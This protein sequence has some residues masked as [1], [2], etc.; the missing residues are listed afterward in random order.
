MADFAEKLSDDVYFWE[1]L[2]GWAERRDPPLTSDSYR[3]AHN[4]SK[5]SHGSAERDSRYP[6]PPH[7]A[8]L[9]VGIE[10]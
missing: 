3:M 7:G 9:V 8:V 6:K 10:P 5:G 2:T 4:P 1:K